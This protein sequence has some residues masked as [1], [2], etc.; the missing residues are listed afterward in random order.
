MG[1][2]NGAFWPDQNAPSHFQ[3]RPKWDLWRFPYFGHVF[4]TFFIN[5]C[6]IVLFFSLSSFTVSQSSW[7]QT[8]WY[9]YCAFVTY[10]SWDIKV[11]IDCTR[12]RDRWL[13]AARTNERRW[14]KRSLLC[15]FPFNAATLTTSSVY[16]LHHLLAIKLLQSYKNVVIPI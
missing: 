7:I 3:M 16:I 14:I 11:Y 1:T 15:W 5:K 2:M 6:M 13:V 4:V 10:L 8:F 9:Q 12:S